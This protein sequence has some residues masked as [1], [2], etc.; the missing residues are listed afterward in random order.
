MSI[1]QQLEQDAKHVVVLEGVEEE[2]TALRVNAREA[3]E[4]LKVCKMSNGRYT[5]LTRW[6]D[7]KSW[8]R[9]C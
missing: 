9:S 1:I 2:T 8:A 3:L 5:S 7:F 4:A 6:I